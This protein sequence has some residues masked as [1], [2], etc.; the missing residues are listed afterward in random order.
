MN[1][2][3][4]RKRRVETGQEAL[5]ISK[6]EARTFLKRLKNSKAV[7]LDDIPFVV[8]SVWQSGQW[9]F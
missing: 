7:G 4:D 3:N 1:E 6:D 9:S 8:V 2:E 5:K